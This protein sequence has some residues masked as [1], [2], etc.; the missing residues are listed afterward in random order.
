[1]WKKSPIVQSFN[2]FNGGSLSNKTIKHKDAIYKFPNICSILDSK[3]QCLGNETL[4]VMVNIL[5]IIL[6]F[7]LSMFLFS[8]KVLDHCATCDQYL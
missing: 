8:F 4:G 6:L 3:A 7:R 5:H 2:R 1:M